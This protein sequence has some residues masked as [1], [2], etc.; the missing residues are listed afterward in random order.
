ME[1]NL[2]AGL[3]HV[4]ALKVRFTNDP[5]DHGGAT[6]WGIT[7]ATLA[8]PPDEQRFARA[9]YLPTICLARSI[10]AR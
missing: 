1:A 6:N 7:A 8:W 9:V 5:S 3:R 10:L 4:L 2:Q